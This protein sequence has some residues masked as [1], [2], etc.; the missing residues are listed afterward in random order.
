MYNHRDKESLAYVS[1]VAEELKHLICE[2]VK[3][4]KYAVRYINICM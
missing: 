4:I 2:K 1:N 3:A